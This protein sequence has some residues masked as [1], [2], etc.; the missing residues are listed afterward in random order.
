MTFEPRRKQQHRHI[1]RQEDPDRRKCR[2]GESSDQESN[3]CHRDHHRTR[4]NHGHRHGVGEL[5]LVEP[6][7]I[8]DNALVQEWD[9]CQ[10]AAKDKRAGLRK[11]EQDV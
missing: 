2:T 5:L 11:E 6:M 9:D 10:S 1:H 7:E 8:L 4:R 3:E